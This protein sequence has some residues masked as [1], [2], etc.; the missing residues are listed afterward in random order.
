MPFVYAGQNMVLMRCAVI[1]GTGLARILMVM[2][3]RTITTVD[4]QAQKIKT[5]TYVQSNLIGTAFA[6][7]YT[8]IPLSSSLTLGI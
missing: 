3:H 8:I 6:C 2:A 5:H 7:C 4:L 1:N